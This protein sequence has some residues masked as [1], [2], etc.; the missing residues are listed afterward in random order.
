MRTFRTIALSLLLVPFVAPAGET[1][2]VKPPVAKKVPKVTEI[3]GEKLV[4]DWFWLRDKQNPEVKAYLDAENAY[5]DAVTKPGEALRQKLYDEAVGRIKETDLSV[6]YRHRGFYWYSRTEKGQQY[7][8]SCRKKGS[9]DAAEQVVLDLNEI[10]KT[11]KF[12]G[13]GTYVP[14]DDGN[15]LAYTIDTTGF[16]LY[17]LQVKDLTTGKLLADKVERVDSVAW[18]AGGKTLFYVVEDSAKRPYRLYRHAVGTAGPDTLVYEETDER[19][20]LGVSRSRDDRWILVQSGSHTQSEWRLIPATEPEAAARIVAPREKDHEYDVEAA[21]DLLYIRTNDG[22]R[23]FRVVTAPAASPGKASWKELVPCRDGVM[24]SGLDAFKGHLVLFER[25]D[26]LPRLSVRDRATGETHRIEVPEAIASVFPEANP[27]FDTKMFRFSYQSFTTAPMVYDYDMATRERTL[28]KKTEV[29]GGYDPGKY[30]SERLYATAA[31]GTKVPVSVVFRKDVPRDG[32]A[33]LFLNGYGSYGA[34]SFVVFNPAL[35]SLLDRGVVYAVAHVR[36]GG[37]LGKKWHDA[38]PDDVEEEHVYRLRRLRRGAGD[39]EDRGEG[40]DRDPGGSAGGL[41]IGAVVNLRPELFRAAILHVPFVDVINTMLD[42]TLPLTVGEFEEWGNPQKRDEYLYMK[43]YSP[44]DNL[45]M[46]AYPSILVKTS[47]ND[48]QVMYWEPAKYVA[49]LRTLKTDTHPLLLKTNMAGGHGGSSGR[50]DRLKETAFDQSFVLS[51][52]GVPDLP[53]SIPVPARPVHT[54]SIVAR[55]PATGQL[56][57]AVQSHWFSVGALVPWAEAGVGAV[58]TQSFVD[59]SYGPLGLALLKA[60]RSAPDALRG[61]LAADAGREVRQVAMIDAAGQVAAH[62]GARCIEAAGHHVGKDYSV[63]S[64]MMRNDTV[65]PAMAKAFEASKGDLAER[66]LAALDAAEAAGGD[67]RGKQS[68]ALIVVSGTP[69][70]RPWQDR[71]FDLRVED[72]PAPLPELRRLVTLARAYNLMNEGDLAVEKK[73]DA[74]A[75]KAYSAA[76]A[77]VPGNAEMTYWTAVSL[78]GM[79]KVDEALPL[80]R[81]TFAIDRS[82][83]EMTPRLSKAGLLPDDPALIARIV[84]E[85]PKAR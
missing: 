32:T 77:I 69:T 85:A 63:Q 18:A 79:G 64:N 48:S 26:A 43:S 2:G 29:P 42:E 51:E 81:K 1:P 61:L 38:R 36:G 33:P 56:G 71:V 49:K 6:P 72:S 82:W 70:G 74:G 54:Y 34:P 27:E 12:V 40:P 31:D 16:R 17:T 67:I 10:A 19:F 57:V 9:L 8:I 11:E 55:D 20:N 84:A 65:W 23:D 21:G 83:A 35:P 4:D 75:L 22:C 28:L 37:D 60:G 24:V 30:R 47:F 73:D 15:L 62:T 7:P 76:Q 25:Q 13:R 39:G 53:A 50:Y 59:A 52:L 44:Y 78:V 5:T 66:M 14:S 68:A 41:L 3:H 58:A 45:K 80:F 46:G